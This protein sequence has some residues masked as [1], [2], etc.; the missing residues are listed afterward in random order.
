M[1]ICF[2]FKFETLTGENLGEYITNEKGTIELDV[3]KDLNI[4]KEQKIKVTEIEVPGN[5]YID[6]DNNSKIIDIE[7]GKDISL[8]FENESLSSV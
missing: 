6:N 4:L 5:Y 1:T 3:Q 8:K 2:K 7:W